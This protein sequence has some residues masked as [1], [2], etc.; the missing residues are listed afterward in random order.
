MNKIYKIQIDTLDMPTEVTTRSFTVSADT[1]SSFIMFVLQEDTLKYYDWGTKEFELGHNDANNNLV[2]TVSGNS[3]TNS[4]DFPSGGGTYIIKLIP[5]IGSQLQGFKNYVITKTILKQSANATVTFSPASTNTANY[6]TFPTTTSTGGSNSVDNFNFNWDIVN[7]NG[8]ADAGSYGLRL[9]GLYNEISDKYWYFTTTDTVDGAVTSS[10]TV[11]ID[12][13]TDIVVGMIISGVSS[14][15]L[16]GTP[17]IINI[18]TST[19]TLTLNSAQ[20]FADGITLT[21]KAVGSSVIKNAIGLDVTFT[22]YPEVSPTVL[23]QTV[24]TDSDGDYTTSTTITLT[25]TRGVSGGN[26]IGYKGI[27][28]DIS[29]T[30]KVTSVSTPDPDGVAGDGAITVQ[31]TQL[32]K[33][34]TVL[35]FVDVFK[36]INFNGNIVINS[37]PNANRTIYLD[38]D[39]LITV[40]TQS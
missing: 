27:D 18:D 8:V 15:S 21:F 13:L 24:R 6:A 38:L 37:Y 40:G 2:V 17:T 34:G 30:N 3:Y 33:A 1:G 20:T 25:D 35:T 26:I 23:T 16:S 19:K 7:W 14:G 11:V 36:T 4:I 10:T 39:K 12:D 29:S 28:V 5:S 31:L 22:N 32:L 9:T